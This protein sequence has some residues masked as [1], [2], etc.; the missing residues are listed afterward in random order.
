MLVWG[1]LGQVRRRLDQTSN[2]ECYWGMY[3]AWCRG[4]VTRRPSQDGHLGLEEEGWG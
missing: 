1:P 2:N 4:L 3:L